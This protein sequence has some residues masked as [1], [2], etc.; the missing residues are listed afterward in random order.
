MQ[1]W[2]TSRFSNLNFPKPDFKHIL[3]VGTQMS[4]IFTTKQGLKFGIGAC[5][6]GISS[7]RKSSICNLFH[8]EKFQFYLKAVV[9]DLFTNELHLKIVEF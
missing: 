9:K 4:S 2:R 1:D 3:V 6:F 7:N 5:K 8:V